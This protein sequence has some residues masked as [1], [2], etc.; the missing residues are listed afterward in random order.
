M[1]DA[2]VKHQQTQQT[3]KLQTFYIMSATAADREE[4]KEGTRFLRTSTPAGIMTAAPSPRSQPCC[5]HA[6]LAQHQTLPIVKQE[7]RQK[8]LHELPALPR[9]LDQLLQKCQQ[10]PYLSRQTNLNASRLHAQSC[11]AGRNLCVR[12]DV[13]T[14]CVQQP[15]QAFSDVLGPHCFV[16]KQCK[17]EFGLIQT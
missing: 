6:P 13:L 10:P 5:L 2:A 3:D 4:R 14:S 8:L 9:G 7:R 12:T 17:V 15:L 1:S 11:C 16:V